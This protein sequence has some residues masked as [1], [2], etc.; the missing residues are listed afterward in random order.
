[1]IILGFVTLAVGYFVLV[2]VFS[3]VISGVYK[4]GMQVRNVLYRHEEEIQ[5]L[6]KQLDN[7]N[8]ILTEKADEAEEITNI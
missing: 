1:M 3:D 2:G 7:L 6:K 4:D 8:E 5:E